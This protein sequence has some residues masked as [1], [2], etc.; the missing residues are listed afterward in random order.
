MQTASFHK[1]NEFKGSIT[2]RNAITS[3]RKMLNWAYE[4]IV[5]AEKK[6]FIEFSV[7]EQTE[8][9]GWEKKTKQTKTKS[10]KRVFEN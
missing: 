3:I 6:M 9:F 10:E 2:R 8:N 4:S 5:E 1:R 7:I